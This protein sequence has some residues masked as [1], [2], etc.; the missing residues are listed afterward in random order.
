M[1]VYHHLMQAYL[2][3][4][5]DCFIRYLSF[6]SSNHDALDH[7][8]QKMNLYF[9]SESLDTLKSFSLFLFVKTMAPSAPR[10]R[11]SKAFFFCNKF[12]AQFYLF[13]HSQFQLVFIRFTSY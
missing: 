10:P 4:H 12:L 2:Q 7:V 1:W 6:R 13:V 9:T 5:S 3:L 11:N 8:D